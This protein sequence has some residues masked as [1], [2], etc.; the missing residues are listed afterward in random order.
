[1]QSSSGLHRH[2]AG[3][4]FMKSFLPPPTMATVA[5]AAI[6]RDQSMRTTFFAAALALAAL[7]MIAQALADDR[8][9]SGLSLDVTYSDLNLENPAGAQVMFRRIKQAA[10]KVCGGMPSQRMAMEMRNYRICVRMA[11]EDA[12]RQLNAPLV[13]ALLDGASSDDLRL[14]SNSAER[15]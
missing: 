14:T 2:E 6:R 10:S 9:S 1:M 8:S 15:R 4:T 13:T 5:G 3:E 7:P 12:V 11:V